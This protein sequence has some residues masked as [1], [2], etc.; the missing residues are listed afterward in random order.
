M[1]TLALVQAWS[2]VQSNVHLARTV[3]EVGFGLGFAFVMLS[4]PVS[5][6][7]VSYCIFVMYR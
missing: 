4:D 5:S 3:T 1:I 2:V 7:P 6:K